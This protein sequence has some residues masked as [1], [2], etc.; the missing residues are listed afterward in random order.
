MGIHSRPNTGNPHVKI[1]TPPRFCA[2]ILL[3]LVLAACGGDDPA[4]PRQPD[5]V[6]T[7]LVVTPDPVDL[8]MAATRQLS[9]TV[10]DR[11]G[12]AMNQL[13]AGFTPQ[14]SSDDTTVVTIDASGLV[15]GVRIGQTSIR[16]AAGSLQKS[17]TARVLDVTPQLESQRAVSL[18]VGPEGGVLETQSNA[19]IGYRLEI[20]PLALAE[21]TTVTLTPISELA[22]APFLTLRG[23][24]RFAPDGLVLREPARLITDLPDPPPLSKLIGVGFPNDGSSLSLHPINRSGTQATLLV[25]HFSGAG[26]ANLE[27]GSAVAP[28]A[29]E[30]PSVTAVFDMAATAS[31]GAPDANTVATI[32]RRWYQDGVRPTLQA[33]ASSFSSLD[34][35]VSEWRL[36]F[37]MMTT[38]P[39]LAAEVLDALAGEI[40]EARDLATTALRSRIDYLNIECVTE[41]LVVGTARV[42]CAAHGGGVRARERGERIGPGELPG[43]AL[44]RDRLCGRRTADGSRAGPSGGTRV[45][46]RSQLCRR[47][48]R[49]LHGAAPDDHL[50]LRRDGF[51][52][53]A[54]VV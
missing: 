11:L 43:V 25:P 37:G 28:P 47:C 30:D 12:E 45:P 24:A 40:E 52:R 9:L 13:P 41:R 2:P 3:A 54:D 26:V 35:A 5:P 51:A 8:A 44:F 15:R 33:A 21:P 22:N 39:E 32:L 6:A 31:N 50:R 49:R 7:S 18:E 17:V 48:A 20:P 19:G 1:S 23:G 16:V 53:L 46:G 42:G 14:W 34:G 29:E 27:D 10:V 36:W 38:F 4:G